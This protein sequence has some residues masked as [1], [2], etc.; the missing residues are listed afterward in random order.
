MNPDLANLGCSA[1]RLRRRGKRPVVQRDAPRELTNLASSP[2]Q[3][4]SPFM[5]QGRQP[6]TSA[7]SVSFGGGGVDAEREPMRQ[8]CR[9]RSSIGMLNIA[10]TKTSVA[11]AAS[12]ENG[13]AI[14]AAA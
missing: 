7:F 1:S 2:A 8:L 11:R 5:A 13:A 4:D 3:F 10:G 9:S 14:T 6:A 12:G